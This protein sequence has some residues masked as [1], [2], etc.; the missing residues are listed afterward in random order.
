MDIGYYLFSFVFFIAPLVLMSL[1]ANQLIAL[2]DIANFSLKIKDF[3]L[4]EVPDKS[5]LSYLIT[6]TITVT[7]IIFGNTILNQG[8]FY[9]QIRELKKILYSLIDIQG[10]FIHSINESLITIRNLLRE[11]HPIISGQ[12]CATTEREKNLVRNFWSNLAFLKRIIKKLQEDDL[13]NK[14]LVDRKSL[15]AETSII[16]ENYFSKLRL[17]LIDLETLVLSNFPDSSKE[18]D[19]KW[20][21]IDLV[22]QFLDGAITQFAV[23]ACMAEMCSIVLLGYEKNKE[24]LVKKFFELINRN[25]GLFEYHRREMINSDD[26]EKIHEFINKKCRKQ[27]LNYCRKQKLILD[28]QGGMESRIHIHPDVCNGRPVI[29]GTR[30]PVQTVMEFLGA[31]DSIEE[32]LEE[33]PSLNREDIY[34]CMQF[35]ARLMANHYEVRKIA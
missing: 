28:H 3:F 14:L 12:E 34:A 9:N 4:L 23:L 5:I 35:A 18:V 30:I 8:K 20:R 32:V 21:N 19:F 25:K 27:K 17:L 1:D 11:I 2:L 26:L 10:A 13:Y 6:V 31:G 33:Y 22:Y 16:V 29:A 24:I 7:G 15:K